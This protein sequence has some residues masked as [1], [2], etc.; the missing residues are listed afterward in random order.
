M[1]ELERQAK[2]K[3][4]VGN[5]SASCYFRVRA[6][7]FSLTLNTCIVSS[8]PRLALINVRVRQKTSLNTLEITET[9]REDMKGVITRQTGGTT[10]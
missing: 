3:R 10:V 6:N 2:K 1:R 9:R 5:I 7:V 4:K 8:V